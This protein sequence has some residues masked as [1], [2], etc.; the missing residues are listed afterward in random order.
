MPEARGKWAAASVDPH[1]EKDMKGPGGSLRVWTNIEDF[2]A[3]FDE[4][5]IAANLTM[6]DKEKKNPKEADLRRYEDEVN[7]AGGSWHSNLL[8]GVA[9]SSRSGPSKFVE[10]APKVDE[11]SQ[12]EHK[13]S[14][15]EDDQK[16]STRGR[17]SRSRSA[18][19]RQPAASPDGHRRNTK[20]T[21]SWMWMRRR[22]RMKMMRRRRWRRG[23]IDEGCGG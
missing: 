7:A 9:G 4:G 6:G 3:F 22:R 19:R 15:T 10:G 8:A 5:R 11:D 23:R 12:V 13:E 20:Y 21:K 17:R 18:R 1:V 2:I 14:L 16:T